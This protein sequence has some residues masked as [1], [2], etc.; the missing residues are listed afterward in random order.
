MSIFGNKKKGTSPEDKS[1]QATVQNQTDF[2]NIENHGQFNLNSNVDNSTHLNIYISGMTIGIPYTMPPVPEYTGHGQKLEDV[3]EK[4]EEGVVLIHD[5]GGMGKTEFANKLGASYYQGKSFMLNCTNGVDAALA[6]C[7]AGAGKD[8]KERRNAVI[9]QIR[10]KFGA[11]TLVVFDNVGKEE[12]KEKDV[13]LIN[14]YFSQAPCRKLITSRRALG[15]RIIRIPLGT[16]DE[17][18]AVEL[19]KKYHAKGEYTD[20]ENGCITD[21]V[22]RSGRH[23]L[24]LKL[25]AKTCN[26]ADIGVDEMLSRMKREGFAIGIAET[27]EHD[28]SDEVFIEHMKKLFDITGVLKEDAGFETL[29]KKLCVLD[30]TNADKRMLRTWCGESDLNRLNSLAKLGW[31]RDDKGFTMHNVVSEVLRQK[32]HPT[33][34]D[35]E[36]TAKVLK[37]ELEEARDDDKLRYTPQPAQTQTVSM[38]NA[39]KEKK[40]LLGDIALKAGLLSDEQGSYENALWLDKRCVEI[41]ETVLSDDSTELATAYN[42]TAVVYHAKGEYDHALEYCEKALA[43]VE[44]V[45][46]REHPNT[47]A[48][49]NNIAEVYRSKGEYD[50]AL[51]YNEKALAIREKVLGR[52]HPA[53]ATSYNNIALVYD[54]KGE[55]DHALEYN[56]KALAIREK[57]LGREHPDTAASYNNIAGVYGNK[58][59]Y[60]RALEYYEKALAIVENVLGKEHPNTAASYNNIANVYRAKGEY[61]HAL[62]Y[63]EKALAIR[64]KVL[65]RE[66][67]Y[68]AASYNNIALVYK[69]KGEYDLALEYYEKALA[70][71][72]NVL[73]REHPDTATSY[74]NIAGVYRAKGEYDLA[75][76][77]HEKALAIDEKVLG[78]EHPSTAIDYNNIA[79]VYRAKGEY[80]RAL[81]YNEKA[82]AIREK[83]LGKEHPDTASS[84]HNIGAL[85]YKMGRLDDAEA[86]LARAL[87]VYAG[88]NMEKDA[89]DELS[90]LSAVYSAKGGDRLD[91][92]AF[93]KWVDKLIDS[94]D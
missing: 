18:E 75:L 67:P 88:H 73:G 49:Y 6:D 14:K 89:D 11:D 37:K 7:C 10:E 47:A 48:S 20:A 39:V 84:C 4:L 2:G 5:W 56:E 24:T 13:D 76:E 45:L 21:I 94:L 25:L 58:G 79:S 82:L 92:A 15:E 46:G 71:F 51:E 36:S 1:R 35:V 16:L 28:G 61:D 23:A 44:R 38:L 41:Y 19:F 65:G 3:Q 22:R 90:W 81:E 78:R 70:I 62:E 9:E 54:D 8:F 85:F 86:N 72:E 93:K 91:K 50:H 77:Y 55:Y 32:L 53:T 74:N 59:E 63:Y 66:H 26:A 87:R 29:F 33:F 43:I 17:A 64:E 52:E 40:K 57:V 34:A 30:V 60:D 31:L 27:V 68:T 42:N 83:V 80:D 69:A 12:E